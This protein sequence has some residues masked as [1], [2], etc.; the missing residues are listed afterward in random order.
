M[1]GRLYRTWYTRKLARETP[2]TYY[3]FGDNMEHR[4]MGGQAA[5]IRGEP[6]A[7]GIPTKW[8]PRMQDSA[9]FTGDDF[10]RGN[11]K[12]EIDDALDKIKVLLETGHDVVLPPAKIGAGLARLNLYAP[13]IFSYINDAIEKLEEEYK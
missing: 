5:A 13:N 8:A 3:V 10:D 1:T 9:F 7:V 12:K 11:V 2:D 4:G 6:N